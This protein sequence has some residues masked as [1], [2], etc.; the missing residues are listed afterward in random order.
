MRLILK[1]LANR[2]GIEA[3]LKYGKMNRYLLA[4]KELPED[5][6]LGWG[7]QEWASFAQSFK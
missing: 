3:G 6:V 1:V 7:D 4:I 2:F 5:M